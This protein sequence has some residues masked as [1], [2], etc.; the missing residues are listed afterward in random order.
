MVPNHPRAK[1]TCYLSCMVDLIDLDNER[2]EL[3]DFHN[4]F[5]LNTDQEQT[6]VAL[7]L[8][9]NPLE[10]LGQCLLVVEPGDPR[11]HGLQ[12]KCIQLNRQ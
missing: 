7:C 1:L 5:R 9:L 3:T 11:L 2:S 4:Y 6:L 12:T 10:L 8:L